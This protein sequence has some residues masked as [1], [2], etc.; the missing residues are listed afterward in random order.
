MQVRVHQYSVL[1]KVVEDI[2]VM[3][4]EENEDSLC[5]CAVFVFDR[6]PYKVGIRYQEDGTKV[7]VCILGH[8]FTYDLNLE[9]DGLNTEYKDLGVRSDPSDFTRRG[10]AEGILRKAL[11]GYSEIWNIPYGNESFAVYSIL[12]L[13]WISYG[14]ESFPVYVEHID[15]GVDSSPS[16]TMLS[17][18]ACSLKNAIVGGSILERYGDKISML[19]DSRLLGRMNFGVRDRELRRGSLL[20]MVFQQNLL[21][22]RMVSHHQRS[23]KMQFRILLAN[24]MALGYHAKAAPPTVTFPHLKAMTTGSIGGFLDVLFN[25][26]TQA[27]LKDNIIVESRITTGVQQYQILKMVN[28]VQ[29]AK[30]VWELHHDQDK[31]LTYFEKDVFAAPEDRDFDDSV[32]QRVNEDI[33]DILLPDMSNY[34]ISEDD[35]SNEAIAIVQ[36]KLQETSVHSSLAREEGEVFE[37]DSDTRRRV[38]NDR[39]KGIMERMFAVSDVAPKWLHRF[40]RHHTTVAH[41]L[42]FR[43]LHDE[44]R[45]EGNT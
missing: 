29:Y 34:L 24:N 14:N 2:L 28:M 20:L 25:F 16:T 38:C 7:R 42:W 26:N 9:F 3:F 11:S 31:A 19:L 37:L 39:A 18:V 15:A 32:L 5:S 35:A 40:P 22:E 43:H 1:V 4:I 30:L 10:V 36:V 23:L 12:M 45:D 13:V 41:H 17:E 6:Q 21:L 27:L 33:K 44:E 8:P